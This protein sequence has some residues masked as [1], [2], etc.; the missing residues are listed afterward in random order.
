MENII[1]VQGRPRRAHSLRLPTVPALIAL[2][3]GRPVAL[4]YC[5]PLILVR[6]FGGPVGRVRYVGADR[7]LAVHFEGDPLTHVSEFRRVDVQVQWGGNALRSLEAHLAT[8][9]PIEADLDAP[10]DPSADASA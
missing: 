1:K 2:L 9:P 3:G 8:N 5:A 7:T 6:V 4:P 10:S